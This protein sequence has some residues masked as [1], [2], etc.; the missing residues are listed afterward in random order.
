VP[1][2]LGMLAG[3]TDVEVIRVEGTALSPQSA[4]QALVRATAQASEVVDAL[5]AAA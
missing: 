3:M 4:E 5:V 2:L 1:W